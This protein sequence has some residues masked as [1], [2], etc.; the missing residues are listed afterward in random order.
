[1]KKIKIKNIEKIADEVKEIYSKII[2]NG[3]RIESNGVSSV[4]DFWQPLAIAVNCDGHVIAIIHS[5]GHTSGVL[6][7]EDD[8]GK[9]VA[10][11][12]YG[13]KLMFTKPAKN[14]H[15]SAKEWA[16]D[17]NSR[18]MMLMDK[19]HPAI[20][21]IAFYCIGEDNI[22]LCYEGIARAMHLLRLAGEDSLAAK[23]MEYMDK[24]S[25]IALT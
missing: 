5:I 4:E 15:E 23:L 21:V 19:E 20:P 3:F 1:M 11:E 8:N 9:I 10:T 17:V 22:T 16:L 13:G 12:K 14:S 2:K 6:I 24:T 18:N 7:A 25:T